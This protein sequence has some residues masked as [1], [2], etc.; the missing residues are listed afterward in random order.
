M[1]RLIVVLVLA[2]AAETACNRVQAA[3]FVGEKQVTFRVEEWLDGTST[4]AGRAGTVNFTLTTDYAAMRWSMDFDV[5]LLLAGGPDEPFETRLRAKGSLASRRCGFPEGC[6]LLGD[7]EPS[8]LSFP[9]AKGESGAGS[10][11][12]LGSAEWTLADRIVT[13]VR[14]RHSPE[15]RIVAGTGGVSGDRARSGQAG[16]GSLSVG[17]G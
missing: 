3:T 2:C 14:E 15:K 9:D 8:R 11:M 17:R 7:G 5:D 12:L 1:V 10:Y 4:S 16:G 13:A 6:S